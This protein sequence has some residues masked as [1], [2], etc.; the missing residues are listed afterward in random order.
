[1]D[2]S[3]NKVE[4]LWRIPESLL[5]HKFYVLVFSRQGTRSREQN[6]LAPD[7]TDLVTSRARILTTP[8]IEPRME[9]EEVYLH[10]FIGIYQRLKSV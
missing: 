2:K 9:L 10:H 5:S 7:Y 6:T 8:A 3:S 4:Q 1:M